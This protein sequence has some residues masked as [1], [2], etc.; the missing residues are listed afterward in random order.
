MSEAGPGFTVGMSSLFER[1]QLVFYAPHTAFLEVRGRETAHD[2][3][4]PT[5]LV[6]MVGLAAHHMTIDTV[7]DLQNP[8]VQR[9]L[10]GMDEEGRQRYEQSAAMLRAHGWMQIPVGVFTSLVVV[11]WVLMAMA[12]SLFQV[13]VNYRQ[14]LVV[15]AYAALVVAA[16]WILQSVLVWSTGDPTLHLGLGILLSDEV[17]AS[18]V[19]RVLMAANPFDV[20]QIAIMAIGLSAMLDVP[21]EKATIAI[22][23]LWMFW[24]VG[25]VGV[26][27][28][29]RNMLPPPQ[30]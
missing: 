19:G 29:S 2:W 26:E 23:L 21:K 10:E 6:C 17:A 7:T 5:L 3:L 11:G 25:G 20:W 27:T 12:R 14:V 30:E 28:M 1:L 8:A 15:K 24:L 4:L 22:L 9:H 13:E 16:E 18:F